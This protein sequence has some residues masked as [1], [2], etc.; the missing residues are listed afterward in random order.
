MTRSVPASPALDS[1]AVETRTQALGREL[2]AAARRESERLSALNRWTEQVL[3]WCLGD[4]ALKRSVLRFIDV[5]PSL[6]GA[7][8]VAAH[9]RD[10]FPTADRRLPPALRAGA[11]L[12]RSGL[13]TAPALAAAVTQAVEQVA[14]QFIADAH[15]EGARRVLEQ[16][17]ARGATCSL[18]LLGEQVLS[19]PEADRYAAESLRLLQDMGR[20]ARDLPA[21]A[22][23]PACGPRL[24]LSLKPSA[25]SPRF[26]PI[27][28]VESVARAVRRLGPLLAAA[29]AEGALLNLDMEH[30]ELRDLT[31]ELAR[32]LLVHPDAGPRASL[33]VVIQAYLRDAEA[34]VDD[35]LAWLAAHERALTVRLVK[36]AY[37]DVEVA[38]A[39]QRTWPVPVHTDK[40]ATDAAFERLTRRLLGAAPLVGTAIASHNV[41]SIAHAMA[42]AEALGMEKTQLEF[43]LLYGMGEALH[44]AIRALGYPVRIYTPIGPLLPGM[45]YLVR[46]LLENTANE[47]FLRQ[48]WLRE[49]TADELLCAPQASA[50]PRTPA[51]PGWTSEP[52]A[53]FSQA[54]ARERMAEA[55]AAARREAGQ[56]LAP[57]LGEGTAEGGEALTVRNP[58]RFEEVLG[59]VAGASGGDV[60]RAVALAAEAQPRWAGRP[61]AER[62]EVLRRAAGVLRE[63]RSALAAWEVLEVGKTWREADADAAEGVDYLEYYGP[64]LLALAQAQPLPQFAGERNRLEYLPRGVAVVIAPWNFPAAILLGMASAALVSGH[65]VILKPAE[66][67][68]LTALRVTQWLRGAGIPPAVVQCL[69]GGGETV[70]AALAAHPGVHAVLFTGSRAVGLGLLRACAHVAPGQRFVKHVVAEMGGKNAILVDEDADLDAAVQGTLTSAFGYGGQKCSAASRVIVHAGVYEPFLQRLAAAADRL[71]IGDPADPATDVGPLIDAEAQR[72]LAAAAATAAAVGQVVYRTPAA[73]VPTQGAFAP[74]VIAAEV[75]PAHPLAR[76]ELFGPLLCVF[77]ARSFEEA[78]RLANDTDYALTG[79]VYSRAPSH[80]AR[81]AAAFDVGNLYINRPI[82]GAL[83]GRQPFGGHRLSGLG[84]QAGGPDYLRQLLLPKTVCENTARH[85]MPLE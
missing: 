64:Q 24:N 47:S 17:A 80:I 46:R 11:T 49:R 22:R 15:A 54:A 10:Y 55:L 62:V 8:A 43:Q 41:R 39:R 71:V 68:P 19:E 34:V 85:G 73:R 69:P 14:R 48:D 53:D 61:A 28:P 83:V 25:L 44:G 40:A 72:R 37:W 29:D 79:G 13:L 77:R 74:L 56:R 67:S 26:D 7:R 16:L 4:P 50:A 65:A 70:G 60:E 57:L 78:L 33:G 35:L 27:S 58:A 38:Q 75:P 30:Y 82:T 84:T 23:V 1:A 66:Q 18:D 42:V 20:A 52:P 45:A 81:A 36:G 2:F 31:L 9:V 5:L 3:A 12:A 76:E 59:T 21:L 63:R 32:H 51:A 6:R